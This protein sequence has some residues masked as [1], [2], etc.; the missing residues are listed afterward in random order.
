M[1]K[2]QIVVNEKQVN[3]SIAQLQQTQKFAA[4]GR[5]PELNVAQLE[6]QL[7]SDSSALISALSDY[8]ASVLDLKA[9]LLSL[10]HI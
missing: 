1:A 6:A 7:A 10:I 3:L 5:V 8:T 2:E 4:V 9:I